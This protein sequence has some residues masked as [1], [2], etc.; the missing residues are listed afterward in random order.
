MSLMYAQMG[1]SV[2]NAWG[3]YEQDKMQAK[4]R[5]LAKKYENAMSAISAAQELNTATANEVSMRDALIRTKEA[6]EVQSM[7]DAAS[8]EAGAAA[9]GV[10]GS[11]VR[12]TMRGIMRSRLQ[13]R[14]AVR[15]KLD[16]L[17]QQRTQ[18][19]RNIALSQAMGRNRDVMPRP[20][21]ASALLG[22]GASLVDIYDSHQPEG[23]RTTDAM[24]R[25]GQ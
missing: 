1:L 18:T 14:Q 22:L 9:A 21:A 12:D 23:Q 25:W 11:S 8:A 10:R 7:K 20:S 19:R 17:H 24:S 4:S 5:K 15:A 6:V 2:V 13:A 16:A 3:Q